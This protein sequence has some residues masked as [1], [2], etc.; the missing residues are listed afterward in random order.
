MYMNISYIQVHLFHYLRVS[1]E[2]ENH[3]RSVGL[4][5][6]LVRALHPYHR[7]MGSIAIQFFVTFFVFNCLRTFVLIVSV[8]LTICDAM[9]RHALST[10]AVEE[11][12]RFIA[13]VGTLISMH[14]LN[15]YC[16]VT[17]YFLLIDR[18]RVVSNFGDGDCGMGKIHTCTREISRR[19]NATRR[20]RWK[21]KTTDKAREF[22]LRAYIPNA[23][24]W[25]AL[26]WIPVNNL[27]T[28]HK[29]LSTL[30]RTSTPIR[31]SLLK[32]Q[33]DYRLDK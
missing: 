20:E 11:M 6:Q 33:T 29:Q 4:I 24:L 26:F 16:L 3:Q 18:L 10:C 17:P 13:L 32:W 9:P 23:K 27:A 31:F 1:Y 25:L 28:V 21:L 14:R 7:V 5:I 8:H 15:S 30:V 22:E 19:R 12:W 2:L